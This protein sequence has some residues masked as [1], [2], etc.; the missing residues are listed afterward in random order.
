M[1]APRAVRK[2][3]CNLSLPARQLNKLIKAAKEQGV[4]VQDILRRMV[5]RWIW[6]GEKE[7]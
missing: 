7:L 4:T 2:I 6:D 3:P 5:D 1:K